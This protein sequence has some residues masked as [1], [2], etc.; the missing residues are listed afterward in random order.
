MTAKVLVV[1]DEPSLTETMA[2]ILETSGFEPVTATTVSEAIARLHEQHFDALLVDLSMPGDGHAVI[3]A[4]RATTPQSLIVVISG[5]VAADQIPAPVRAQADEVLS[6]PT[7]IPRL[8]AL[9]R[10]RLS[11]G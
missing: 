5:H 10:A 4:M 1:D 11:Q 9:L 3:A 8:L 7:E 6:K 2:V